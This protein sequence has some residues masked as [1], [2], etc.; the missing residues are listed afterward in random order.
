MAILKTGRKSEGLEGKGPKKR[1]ENLGLSL[2]RIACK[3]LGHASQTQQRKATN[4]RRLENSKLPSV[5]KLPRFTVYIFS[6]KAGKTLFMGK[7]QIV[8]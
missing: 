3:K 5:P 4:G 1:P 8:P 7:L 6:L 2:F